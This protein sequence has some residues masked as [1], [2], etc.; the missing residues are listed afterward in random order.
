MQLIF[1]K[2]TNVFITGN[3]VNSTCAGPCLFVFEGKGKCLLQLRNIVGLENGPDEINRTFSSSN[4]VWPKY[5][6]AV[7]TSL[8]T[9]PQTSNK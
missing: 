8:P 9:K 7:A 3:N 6:E 1:H 4:R 2:G 5:D